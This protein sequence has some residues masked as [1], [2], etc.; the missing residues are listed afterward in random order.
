MYSSELFP[1]QICICFSPNVAVGTSR[2]DY[3]EVPSSEANIIL[4]DRTERGTFMTDPVV[5]ARPMT[6]AEVAAHLQMSERRVIQWL[7]EGQLLGHR[8]DT[9]WQTST[10]HLASFLEARAN[11]PA[12]TKAQPSDLQK[13]GRKRKLIA[14]P[15]GE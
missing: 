2:P 12:T 11:R 6:P 14:H 13:K 5:K 15:T 7:R 10:L 1:Q 4:V 9:Q 8:I 3:C